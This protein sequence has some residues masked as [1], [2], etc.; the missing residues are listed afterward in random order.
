ME[1][2]AHSAG[3][4][5]PLPPHPLAAHLHAVE[6]LAGKFAERF[7]AADW[8]R[9]AGLWHD[10]G[11][12]R[13][14]FQQY[15]RQSPDAHI[16]QRVADRD[17]THSAAGALH[18]INALGE[19]YGTLLAFLIAGHH[20]GLPDLHAGDGRA[21][22]LHARLHSADGEREYTSAMAQVIPPDVLA[23]V[24]PASP[25]P[26]GEAGF[27]LWLRMLF[28]C[29]VDA[30]FLDTE[31]YYSPEKAARRGGGPSISRMR[32]VLDAYLQRL[33]ETVVAARPSVIDARRVEVL[34]AC[35]VKASLPP[36]F[37]TLTVPTGGGKTLSSLAFALNHA[38][39]HG[40][41]GV[42]YAIPYTSII[43]Q[44]AEVFRQ[45]FA[46]LGDEVV[47]EHHSNLDIDET[48]EDHASRLAAENWDAPLVVTT[49]VQLFESLFAARTSRCRKLHNLVDRVI[50][51][52]EAQMLPRDFLAPVVD[53]L[54]RLVA[55]YGVTVLLCTATQPALASRR[56]PVTG[57]KILAGID[58]AREIIDAPEDL[59]TALRRVD[60]HMPKD[61]TAPRPWDDIASE[62]RCRDCVLAIVNTRRDARDLFNVLA[63]ADAVHLSALMCAEH[64]SHVIRQVRERLAARRDGSSTR[65]LRVISTQLVEA[66]VDLDFPVVYR[67]LAG[68]DSIAQA[69]GRCNREG[70]LD[71][72]GQVY[73]FV[74]PTKTP[75]G[76][77][78][79]GAQATRELAQ[80]ASFDPLAPESLRRYFDQLYGKGELDK[81]GILGLLTRER[82][83]FRTAAEKFRLIDGA[84]ETVI[85]PFDPEGGPNSASPVHEWLG[86]LAGDG[87]ARWARRKLQ[88]YTVNVPR[89]QFDRMVAQHDV[90]E[91][92]GL[93]VALDSRYDPLFGLLLPDDH[94]G[95]ADYVA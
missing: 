5:S 59:Y 89:W 92:A 69:A 31:A 73:V 19:G 95:P 35:S 6:R 23:G 79:Q 88:R 45:V 46:P 52:D 56:E 10:L 61:F 94:G 2:W 36:G 17:K 64:R 93:W 81:N 51:L 49:N 58:D 84:G 48:S 83:A 16:E 76:L 7:G 21:A 30:D 85:V 42:V 29:L 62:I 14:G 72:K 55:H 12:Y 25:C 63:D 38:L 4:D 86:V 11:K 87:N 33:M 32:E 22:S 1:V 80:S 50:V 15:I 24:R 90:V 70:R 75:P 34:S 3:P 13:A 77:I 82:A 37:F 53:V 65:P 68:L 8:A 60:V 57:R 78:L 66:G 44:N 74:A 39:V 67:A 26:G 27:A 9:L 40:K 71:G 18:A 28:S 47:V 54:K 41:R 43:E 91:R 20:A